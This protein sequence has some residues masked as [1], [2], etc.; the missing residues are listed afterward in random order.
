MWVV[1]RLVAEIG[2][3][4]DRPWRRELDYYNRKANRA[5]Q[6]GRRPTTCGMRLHTIVSWPSVTVILTYERWTIGRSTETLCVY[7]E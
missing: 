2:V 7:L 4:V 5:K 3:T 1:C 6:W